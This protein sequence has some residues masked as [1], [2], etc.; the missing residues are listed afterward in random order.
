M[1]L[2]GESRGEVLVMQRRAII[3]VEV[4]KL[5]T[6]LKDNRDD[7]ILNHLSKLNVTQRLKTGSRDLQRQNFSFYGRCFLS[8]VNLSWNVVAAVA[9]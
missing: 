2:N 9:N 8:I 1:F 7:G 6:I 4:D 3:G 5:R